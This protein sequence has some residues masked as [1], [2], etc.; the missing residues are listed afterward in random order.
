[1]KKLPLLL[2]CFLLLQKS[3]AQKGSAEL[4]TGHRYL[5]YQHTL[6]QPLSSQSRLGWQ[7]IATLIKRYQPV[8]GKQGH[9]DELM[10]QAYLS[11]ALSK[12]LSAKGGLFYTN[13]GGYKPS[14]GL[15]AVFV[16]QYG[17]IVL[18]PR[19]DVVREPAYELF[20]FSE[21]TLP[22]SKKV[23]LV[24]RLQAMS[25]AS[26]KQHNRSYQLIRLGVERN[27]LQFGAGLTLDQFGTSKA[28]HC[29]A[30]LFIRKKW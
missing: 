22:V 10:N 19:V 28:V 6:A 9:T 23:H 25:N 15:Q 21:N 1:M 26:K 17:S 3:G 2:F 12:V 4:M 18:S 20:V 29:N 14:V 24:A 5:H 7:H 13:A 27:N 11:F 16:H 8:K 30:G